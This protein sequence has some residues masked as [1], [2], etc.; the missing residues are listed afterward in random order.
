MMQVIK[1]MWV[2]NMSLDYFKELSAS[3]T[4]M[5]QMVIDQKGGMTKY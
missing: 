4:R 3:M 1:K 2:H 5:L